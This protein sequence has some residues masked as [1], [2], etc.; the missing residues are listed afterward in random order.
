M[1]DLSRQDVQSILQQNTNAI[2]ARTASRQ[3]ITDA[4]QNLAQRI[5]S[6]QDMQVILDRYRDRSGD[7]LVLTLQDQHSCVKQILNNY[8]VLIRRLDRLESRL[9]DVQ[10][11]VQSVKMTNDIIMGN[12]R[13]NQISLKGETT[14]NNQSY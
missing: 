5:C 6:K 9:A 1:G 2:L 11:N 12:N 10:A 8:D 3:D 7:R 14:N 4:V 13:M